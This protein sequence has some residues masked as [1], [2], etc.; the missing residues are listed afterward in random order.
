M[1]FCVGVSSLPIIILLCVCLL[2]YTLHWTAAETATSTDNR[3]CFI[4]LCLYSFFLSHA[5][6]KFVK[7]HNYV[8]FLLLL[9]KALDMR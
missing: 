7:Q 4:S 9:M 6:N 3:H 2:N 1:S 5:Y 8:Y